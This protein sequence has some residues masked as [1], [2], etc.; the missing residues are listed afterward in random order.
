MYGYSVV[1]NVRVVSTNVVV[2]SAVC[3]FNL[4]G[5]DTRYDVQRQLILK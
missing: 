2:T 5:E 3:S 1:T 4:I